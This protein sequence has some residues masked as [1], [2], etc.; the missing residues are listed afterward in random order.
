MRISQMKE[1]EDFDEILVETLAIGWSEQFG[2]P[3]ELSLSPS[4][5]SR[6]AQEWRLQPL[7][8]MYCAANPTI[9]AREFLRDSFRFTPFFWRILPQWILG[10]AATTRVGLN[11]GSQQGFW[12]VPEVENADSMVLLP[13][14]QRIRVFDFSRGRVRTFLKVGFEKATMQTEIGIRAQDGPFT[15]IL[16]YGADYTWFE[17]PILAG[18]D[19]TRCPPWF[20]KKPVIHKAFSELER[21]AEKSSVTLDSAE[22]LKSLTARVRVACDAVNER[23]S[24]AQCDFLLEVVEALV[25]YAGVARE[26]IIRG[27]HGDFQP[28]NIRVD[29]AGKK[30]WLLDW[31]HSAPRSQYYDRIVFGLR[32]RASHGL[33]ARAISFVKSTNTSWLFDAFPNSASWRTSQLAVVLIEDLLWYLSESL[34]GPTRDISQGLSSYLDELRILRPRLAAI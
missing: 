28:G 11:I 31:E 26:V 21:W 24:F 29:P 17:E 8:S 4:S 19:L 9:E 32:T 15:P 25:V 16:D 18:Y 10:T 14:N 23:F 22:Y 3:V 20:R 2:H 30:V 5:S 1:R 34:T 7:L 12:V 13:G 33:A 6:D 27:S